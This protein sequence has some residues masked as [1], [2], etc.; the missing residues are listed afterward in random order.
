MDANSNVTRRQFIV[1][2]L[3]AAGGLA[4]GFAAPH[5]AEAAM[6]P[7]IDPQ[8]WG[9]DDADPK[10]FNAWL[11]IEPDDTVVIRH[12]RAEMGQGSFTALTMCVAKSCN[13]IGRR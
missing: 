2:T 12:G 7:P 13:A 9:S 11:V 3:S 8:P 5:L 4:I 1:T 10:E 6:Q